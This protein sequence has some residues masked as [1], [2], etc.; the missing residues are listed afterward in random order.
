MKII[1]H[2]RYPNVS[3]AKRFKCY[4]C[5]CIFEADEKEYSGYINF[6]ELL[7]RE[8]FHCLCPECHFIADEMRGEKKND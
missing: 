4:R 5:G 7:K 1:E 6:D 3:T 2:G 8:F